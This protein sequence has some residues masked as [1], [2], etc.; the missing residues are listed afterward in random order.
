[1]RAKDRRETRKAKGKM[2]KEG[3]EA[4]R[5]G[6]REYSERSEKRRSRRKE[7]EEAPP[8]VEAEG[9]DKEKRCLDGVG[10]GVEG[11]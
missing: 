8:A 7:K 2:E 1:M 4:R 9:L 5:K 6:R 3:G 10:V 11:G